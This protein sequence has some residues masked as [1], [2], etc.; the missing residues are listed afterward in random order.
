MKSSRPLLATALFTLVLAVAGC[1]SSSKS[2]SESSA[3]SSTPSSAST[4]AP[5]SSGSSGGGAVAINMQ[6]IA[7]DPKQ[8]T[9]K[10][11]QTVTW[12]N[13]DATDHNVKADSGAS[14]SSKDFGKG[15]TYSY[16]LTKAGTITYEC[17]IHPG[18]TATL[19]VTK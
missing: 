15:G 6:N 19:S 5:S 9:A 13:E 4:P 2:S 1:G 12:T 10:V 16:K 17:T 7:F 8:A 11:G 3:P 18:M 14:F